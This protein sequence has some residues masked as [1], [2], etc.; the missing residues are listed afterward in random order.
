MSLAQRGTRAAAWNYFGNLARVVLQF[1][2]GV[3]LSR[4][5]GPQG[6]GLVAIAMLIIGFGQLFLDFG[7]NA[8]IVQSREVRDQDIVTL[9]TLQILVGL[10]MTLA[11]AGAAPLIAAFFHQPDA[12]W[13]IRAMACMFALRALGLTAVAQLNR[14]LKFRAIQMG[15]LGGYIVG[16]VVIGVP[17]A[18]AG[19]GA[20]SVVAAQLSQSAISSIVPI[21]QIGGLHRLSL[22]GINPGMLNFGRLVLSANLGSWA[23]VNMD[24][25]LVGH[26]NG[27]VGLAFYNRAIM[28]ANSA[29]NA[30]LSG[31][32]GVLFAAAARAQ[33]NPDGCRK[34]LYT[35]I[36]MLVLLIGPVMCAVA[37]TPK[38][39]VLALYGA[40]WLP[41]AGLLAPL[42]LASVINGVI[43]FFG[44]IIMGIGRV[45]LE[46]RAQWTAALVMMPVVYGVAHVSLVAVAWSIIALYLLRLVLLYRALHQILPLRLGD[47]LRAL[48]PGSIL[49][50]LS[51]ATAYSVDKAMAGNPIP[52]TLAADMAAAGTA[53]VIGAVAL[54]RVLLAGAL[55]TLV[56]KSGIAP[57][58]FRRFT[59]A[60]QGPADSV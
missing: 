47:M 7:I 8:A 14:D 21:V 13:V 54:H 38:T 27:S 22:R 48:V 17:M 50:A 35:C 3:L 52:I 36:E 40:R 26:V 28:L 1:G 37:V 20:W 51:A 46:T 56:L 2:I 42:C 9:G 59:L 24:S 41:G 31:L 12:V 43:G 23:L 6:F 44:P 45:E 60:S 10:A 19:F 25:M 55:G 4:L 29:T 30:T 16:Y 34:A 57:I 18:F 39:V 15:T 11:V 33:D 5:I 58:W 49:S 32:Q 53:V